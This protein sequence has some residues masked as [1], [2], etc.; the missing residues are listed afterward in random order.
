[1]TEELKRKTAIVWGY[2]LL[3]AEQKYKEWCHSNNVPCRLSDAIF[4]SSR[5]SLSCNQEKI[6]GYYND[7]ME[8]RVKLINMCKESFAH[9]YN[10]L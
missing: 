9:I 6:R 8:D 5:M 4:L 10:G 2:D 7:V 3:E 1:M